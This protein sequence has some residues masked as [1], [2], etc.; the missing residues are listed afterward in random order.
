MVLDGVQALILNDVRQGNIILDL[1]IRRGEEITKSDIE[2]VYGMSDDSVAK[3]KLQ[4]VMSGGLQILE[5][6]PSYGA[7][8]LILFK[9]WSLVPQ[10][11]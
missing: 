3:N 4:T 1:V 11:D 10:T 5:I 8:G 2:Q 7:E 9:T 6:H